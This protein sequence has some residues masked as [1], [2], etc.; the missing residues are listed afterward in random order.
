MH[1]VRMAVRWARGVAILLLGLAATLALAVPAN[2]VPQQLDQQQPAGAS[3]REEPQLTQRQWDAVREELDASPA[4]VKTVREEGGV[5][6]HIYA[7]PGAGTIVLSEP[8]EAEG[9]QLLIRTG[10]CGF[11]AVCIYF[12]RAEQLAIV[13]GATAAYVGLICRVTSG[14]GCIFAGSI[15][16]A[17]ASL[18]GSRGGICAGELRVR[19]SLVGNTAASCA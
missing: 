15:V 6:D 3:A 10:G 2:A 13:A 4:L 19:V 8:I 11:G 17:A 7:T 16:A 12:S 18:L 9:P 5:R 1:P 14:I